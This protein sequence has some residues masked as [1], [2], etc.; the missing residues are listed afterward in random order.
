HRQPHQ[1]RSHEH[2]Q[3]RTDRAAPQSTAM[4]S[5]RPAEGSTRARRMSSG[6][7]LSGC[8]LA[9]LESRLRWFR[10]RRLRFRRSYRPYQG[11][12]AILAWNNPF[13]PDSLTTGRRHDDIAFFPLT[14]PITAGAGSLAIAISLSS[15]I[16]YTAHDFA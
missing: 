5:R 6:W 2:R 7:W 15:K 1:R 12:L 14:M 13:R 11:R 4:V 10:R 8:L 3:D 9:V 16:I